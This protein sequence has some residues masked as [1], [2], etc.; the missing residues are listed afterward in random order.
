MTLE[1]MGAFILALRKSAGMTQQDLAERVGVTNKSVSR[2]ENGEC[3]PDLTLIPVLADLFGVTADELLRGERRAP[4]EREEA[5]AAREKRVGALVSAVISGYGRSVLLAS[6]APLLGLIA[7]LAVAYGARLPLLGV[8]ICALFALAGAVVAIERA[9][10][11]LHAISGGEPEGAA[12]FDGRRCVIRRAFTPCAL[13]VC[14]IALSVPYLLPDLYTDYQNA[15]LN[16]TSWL[17]L[18]PACLAA[19]AL[20]CAAASAIV[21]A[22]LEKGHLAEIGDAG[23]ASSRRRAIAL[24][25]AAALMAVSL[26]LCMALSPLMGPKGTEYTDFESFRARMETPVNCKESHT[27]YGTNGERTVYGTVEY[28]EGTSGE[29][30]YYYHANM[31]I[32]S[33]EQSPSED[34]LP[35][36]V[37]TRPQLETDRSAYPVLYLWPALCAI[38]TAVALIAL[39]RDEKKV[40]TA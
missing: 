37:Y 4:G 13:A 20:L 23:R 2:W 39:R 6:A 5:P 24:A 31:D 8:G 10:R 27:V 3:A 32:V 25:A 35:V 15:V 38:F 36:T 17:K 33:V 19:A 30:Q 1:N 16:F 14:A 12:V 26:P 34:G 22:Q 9:M 18:A 21:H 29:R 28:L 40:P 7:L 11:A